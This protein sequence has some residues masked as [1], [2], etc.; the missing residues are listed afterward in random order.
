MSSFALAQSGD[1]EETLLEQAKALEK[2]QS[3]SE[4]NPLITSFP[5]E[6]VTHPLFIGVDDVTVPSY[7]GDLA[8]NWLQAFVGAEVW[9]AAYDV[10][11]NKV[12]FNDGATLYE[13]L[14][15][16]TIVNL[17]GT[18]TD[19]SG[20]TYTMVALAFYDDVLYGTRNGAPEGVHVINTTTL[21]ATMFIDYVDADYDF[22]GLSVDPNTGNFYGTNDDSTP[23]GTGLYLINPDGTGTLIAAYPDAQTD[24]D[25]LAV[26][27]DGFA[28]LVIDQAGSIYVYDFVGGTY[29]TPLTNPWVS[30]EVFCGG[31]WIYEAGSGGAAFPEVL[32]YSFNEAGFDSTKNDADPGRGFDWAQ[33]MGALTLVADAGQCGDALMGAGGSSA[34]DYVN[35][36]WITD[37]GTSDW[38]ISLWLSNLVDV[39]NIHYLFGDNTAG[40]FRCFYN[41]VAPVGG[42]ILRGPSITEVPVTGVQPGPTVVHFVYD[43]SVPEISAYVNGVFQIAIAQAAPLD[44]NGTAPFKIGGYSSSS[45]LEAGGLLDEFRFY[46]RALDAAEVLA[47]WNACPVPVELTSFTASVNDN[48]VTLSWETATEVNNSG[49]EIERKSEVGVYDKIGF[50][51][52]FGTTTEHRAYSFSDVNLLPGN[53]TYRLKQIDYNGSFEYSDPVE[54]DIVI[55]DVYSLHQNYPNPFNPSTK[56]TFTL[57]ANAQVTLKVFDIL[58]Q[59]VITLINQ[60]ITAGVHTYDFD[61]SGFNSGVYFYRIEANAIDGTN[62]TNVKKMILLK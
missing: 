11:N 47:T 62:F 29:V 31:A 38:T 23:F 40:S 32:Y 30:S 39:T 25:G 20:A 41:G 27:D 22:G 56:I 4:I 34:T 21:V 14:V 35:T 54:V 50:V 57:A 26:S 44:I 51:P 36:G 61:A 58:G 18:I 13:W 42:I 55:P 46:D 12:Y 1:S 6:A 52:G 17:L 28:Y 7:V 59:E 37:I 19:T 49:F 48:D 2:E 9:G 5:V 10:D 45:G 33:V 60:D 3:Q 43:S 8:S 53:Y 24:I 16:D 15:G